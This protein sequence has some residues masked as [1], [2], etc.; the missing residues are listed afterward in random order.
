[1][2][3]NFNELWHDELLLC[4]NFLFLVLPI[5]NETNPLLGI[6]KSIKGYEYED[7]RRLNQKVVNALE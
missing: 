7:R 1:M 4:L 3:F 5:V 6:R 2:E